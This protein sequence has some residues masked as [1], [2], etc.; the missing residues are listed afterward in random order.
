MKIMDL[1]QRRFGRLSVLSRA[2]TML[3]GHHPTWLCVCDCGARLVV[4]GFSLR[5]GKSKSCGCLKRDT[6]RKRNLSHGD[7]VRKETSREYRIWGGMKTRCSNPSTQ[8]YPFYGG[9][10]IK[11]CD[12]WKQ[13]ANFLADMGRAPDG[14]SLDRLNVNADYE[15][16]NCR[17]ATAEEQARNRRTDALIQIGEKVIPLV[18]LPAYLG[19][20][21]VRFGF[22]W[23]HPSSEVK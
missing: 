12:R 21:P 22:I 11:V 19:M 14:S 20:K 23:E 1:S 5:H 15:P 16:S 17:W 13:F 8:S 2:G 18:D 9:R 4:V 6:T 7:A 10:G 3:R